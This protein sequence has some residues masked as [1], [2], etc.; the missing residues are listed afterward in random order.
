MNIVGIDLG[1]TRIKTGIL[2]NGTLQAVRMIDTIPGTGFENYLAL[3][4]ADI[5]R[6]QEATLITEL[7]AIGLAFPGLVDTTNNRV[8]D[9]NKKYDDAPAL[10]LTEWAKDNFGLELKLENDARLACMGEWKYGAGKGTNDMVMCTL[11][12][13]VGTSAVI[14]GKVL[15]GK[16]FQAG[17]LG[18]HSI[19]DFQTGYQCTCG[20]FGCVESTASTWRIKSLAESH[21]LFKTSLLSTAEKIDIGLIFE[22]SL[23]G[24]ELA[25]VLREHC[26]N[27]W[28]AGIINLIHA[29]DPEVVVLGGGIMNSGEILIPE[30]KRIIKERAWCP[31]GIPEIK[32]A[33]YPDTAALL[34]AMTLFDTITTHEKVSK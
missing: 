32:Q 12:T 13:G 28:A 24:D 15:R 21:P 8:I 25:R 2:T 5:I 4:Q 7:D 14:N 18:G 1:G 23:R 6:L 22:L 20:G 11:G 19:I 9:T 34:G 10:N 31:S 30:F 3:I 16:H 26:I 17:I 33:H 29:Y 27:A